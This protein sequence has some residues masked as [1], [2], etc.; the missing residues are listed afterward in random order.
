MQISVEGAGVR[1]WGLGFGALGFRVIGF[2]VIGFSLG[3][4]VWGLGLGVLL[5][6]SRAGGEWVLGPLY[7]TLRDYHR[8][9]LPHSLLR[10]RVFSFLGL[11]F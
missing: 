10:T 6:L 2:R 4:R 3:V 1:V 8:D 11:G 7:G 9:P 5:V